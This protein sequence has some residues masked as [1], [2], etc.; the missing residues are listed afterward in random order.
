M[1]L[2]WQKRTEEPAQVAIEEAQHEIEE[3]KHELSSTVG[4]TRPSI[5]SKAKYNKWVVAEDNRNVGA[6]VREEHAGLISQRDETRNEFLEATHERTNL[7]RQQREAAA[8]R[9]R[10]HRAAMQARGRE[11]KSRR[12]DQETTARTAKEQYLQ[13]GQ[14]NA[15]IHGTELRERLLESRAE[16]DEERRRNAQSLKQAQLERAEQFQEMTARQ[17]SE[18]RDRVARIRS[19]TTGE[20]VEASKQYFIQSRKAV[21]DDVRES[22]TAWKTEVSANFQQA[23]A[24]AKVQRQAAEE[25]RRNV[26]DGK[27]ILTEERKRQAGE[28]RDSIK[29]IELHKEHLKLSSEFSKREGHDATFESRFVPAEQAIAVEISTYEQVATSHRDELAKRADKPR[30]EITG[31]P[32]WNTF[33]GNPHDG[34]FFKLWF[35]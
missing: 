11:L 14:R 1:F 24:H 29:Q 21:A 19:E 35:N 34:G 7:T 10:A 22:V 8:E 28:V 2:W 5:V 16:K 9:V 17:I 12:E 32:A 27:K 33:F 18:R 30:A 31:R 20:A 13:Y 25:T 4:L 15:Q 3:L 23:L 26:I 6:Q